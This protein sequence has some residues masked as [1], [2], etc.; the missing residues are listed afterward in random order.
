MNMLSAE[1]VNNYIIGNRIYSLEIFYLEDYIHVFASYQSSSNTTEFELLG[2]GGH[3]SLKEVAIRSAILDLM[4][5]I[6]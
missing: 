2:Y 1:F 5:Q 4:Q 3:S 6:Q